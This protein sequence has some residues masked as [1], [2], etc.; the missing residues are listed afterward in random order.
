FPK[1]HEIYPQCLFFR[2]KELATLKQYDK[3]IADYSKL[4]ELKYSSIEVRTGR[5]Q[6]FSALKQ[7]KRALADYDWLLTAEP[8]ND[9]LHRLRGELQVKMGD[10]KAALDDLNLAVKINPSPRNFRARAAV[11]EASGM[12]DQAKADR[13]NAERAR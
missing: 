8:A 7:F 4:V 12:P 1:T 6:C 2:A 13:K 10:Q 11:F 5:A 3:A 9:D